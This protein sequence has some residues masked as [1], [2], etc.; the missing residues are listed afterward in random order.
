MGCYQLLATDQWDMLTALGSSIDSN[1][2]ASGCPANPSMAAL[3]GLGTL[4]SNDVHPR[5]VLGSE[6]IAAHESSLLPEGPR[7]RPL[8]G[9]QE[10]PL[11]RAGG[12]PDCDTSTIILISS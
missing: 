2:L 5:A 4:E 8:R 9:L 3:V 7:L 11:I 12:Q 10:G 1:A 6:Q